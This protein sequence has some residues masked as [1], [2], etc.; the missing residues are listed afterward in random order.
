MGSESRPEGPDGLLELGATQCVVRFE[1]ILQHPVERVWAALT[2]PD[3]LAA[4]WGRAELSLVP[5]GRFV[6]EWINTDDQGNRAT[7]H[8]TITELQPPC[9]LELAGDLHGVLRFELRPDGAATHLSFSSTLALPEEFRAKVLA[10]WHFHL[11]AL[12]RSLD[13]QPVDL[14]RLPGWDE[15]HDRY[16]GRLDG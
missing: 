14:A 11:D 2:E 10:G 7:M 16:L 9:L 5:G 12:A 1:R 6:L 3:R 15:L 4:W 8:A 13:G